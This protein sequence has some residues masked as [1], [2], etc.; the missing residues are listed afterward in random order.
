MNQL[1]YGSTLTVWAAFWKSRQSMCPRG[2]R[3]GK[4]LDWGHPL[5]PTPRISFTSTS[6]VRDPARAGDRNPMRSLT[7]GAPS[8]IAI[9]KSRGSGNRLWLQSAVEQTN[10]TV[11]FFHKYIGSILGFLPL[12]HGASP[13]VADGGV[14][15]HIWRFTENMSNEQSW[16]AD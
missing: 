11:G 4:S 2:T 15:L 12:R 5:K 7:S 8:T 13:R 1:S 3:A 10:N 14:G 6:S 16:T 9:L